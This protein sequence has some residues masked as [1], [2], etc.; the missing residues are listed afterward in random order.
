MFNSIN[1]IG[2]FFVMFLVEKAQLL[3]ITEWNKQTFYS[4]FVSNIW[5]SFF[6]HQN[7]WFTCYRHWKRRLLIIKYNMTT[8]TFFS[9]FLIFLQPNQL[10]FSHFLNVILFCFFKFLSLV[11]LKMFSFQLILCYLCFSLSVILYGF[12]LCCLIESHKS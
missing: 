8:I 2:F 9:F 10:N 6:K 11:K 12:F 1:N 5:E 7:L 3:L 4:A